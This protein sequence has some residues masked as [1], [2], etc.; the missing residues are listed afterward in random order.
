MSA[1][2]YGTLLYGLCFMFYGS[3]S[4]IQIDQET[5]RMVNFEGEGL[6]SDRLEK[7]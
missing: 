7:H 4:N 5:R 1:I 2:L 6:K 3:H